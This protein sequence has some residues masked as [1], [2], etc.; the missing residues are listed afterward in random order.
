[1]A[2]AVSALLLAGAPLAAVEVNRVV[3]RVNDRIVTL[4]DFQLRL[5]DRHNQINSSNAAPD[6][7]ARGLAEAPKGVLRD[8]LDENLLLS[9][10]D[11]LDIVPSAEMMAQAEQQA[12]KN[13]GIDDD[14]QFRQALR[15]AGMSQE[16]FR[17]RVRETLMYQEV[18]DRDVMSQI[19]VTD[20]EVQRYYRDHPEE[21]SVPVRVRLRELVVLEASG[22]AADELERT[23]RDLHSQL[24]SGKSL[25]DLAASGVGTGTT[26]AAIDLGWV[27]TRELDPALAAAVEP[28]APGGY[29][30]PVKA[31]G[32]WHVVQLAE[33]E[34]AHVRPYEE[35]RDA[36][37]GRER[38]KRYQ[39]RLAD[40]MIDLEEKA[41]ISE[42]A[43]PEAQGFRRE[44][45]KVPGS[46]PL[47]A[48]RTDSAPPAAPPVSIDVPKP[49]P[50]EAVPPP[51]GQNSPR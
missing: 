34:D 23:A 45:A 44:R 39:E 37:R 5:A 22:L 43:P 10:A 46:D 30:E 50:I 24:Q 40:Y 15:Q 20:E 1:M 48:L 28:L 6:D 18:L 11:Q 47:E 26:S 7:K 9:R 12:R 49:P 21:F 14:D 3:L 42:N 32:G 29:A 38:S 31:R 33:R 27:E 19:H 13:W 51:G 35:V 41:Y 25:D 2:G 4:R 36:V 17:D 16:D 8:F